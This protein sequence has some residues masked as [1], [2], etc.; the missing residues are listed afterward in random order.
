MT[1]MDHESLLRELFEIDPSLREREANVRE[2]LATLR[3]VGK[4]GVPINPQF[5]HSLRADLLNKVANPIP[6]PYHSFLSASLRFAPLSALAILLLILLPGG[7]GEA[8]PSSVQQN[9]PESMMLETAPL[10]PN[11]KLRS[12][13]TVETSSLMPVANSAQQNT[14]IA[15]RQQAGSSVILDEVTLSAPGFVL[16]RTYTTEGEEVI[17]GKSQ[18]LEKGTTQQLSIQVREPLHVGDLFTV[19]LVQDDGSGLFEAARDL[20][21]VEAEAPVSITLVVE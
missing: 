13:D 19:T 16:V 3:A 17:L 20:P 11:A 14:I 4:D 8:P 6:S 21:F 18:L 10:A 9:V 7:R 15:A 1:P 5:V 12:T 2:I